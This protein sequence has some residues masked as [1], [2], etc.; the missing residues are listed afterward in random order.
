MLSDA[1]YVVTLP[2]AMTVG[3]I[4]LYIET[5][6]KPEREIENVKPTWESRTGLLLFFLLINHH[7]NH[8]LYK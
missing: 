3:A 4:G 1:A 6:T 8:F 2:I 7:L 5:R